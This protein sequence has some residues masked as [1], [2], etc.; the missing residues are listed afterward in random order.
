MN[1]L[2]LIESLKIELQQFGEKLAELFPERVKLLSD[3]KY[4]KFWGINV[5]KLKTRI[6]KGASL[7][8]ESLQNLKNNITCFLG[9]KGLPCLKYIKQV[10]DG[11]IKPLEFIEKVRWELARY[12][13]LIKTSDKELSTILF[14]NPK[15]IAFLKQCLNNPNYP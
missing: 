13:N 5:N 10:Q 4:S 8:G 14:G 12:S 7:S 1:P 9:K 6:R 3:P 2:E 15:Y 11:K